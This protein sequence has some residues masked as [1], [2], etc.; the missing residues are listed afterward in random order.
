VVVGVVVIGIFIW[1][2]DMAWLGLALLCHANILIICKTT[3]CQCAHWTRTILKPVIMTPFCASN[4]TYKHDIW[5][6]QNL[7]YVT[8]LLHIPICTL[9]IQL[10]NC[11]RCMKWVGKLGHWLWEWFVLR[12]HC[13]IEKWLPRKVP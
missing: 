8:I 13:Q 4:L 10:F 3:K 6:L 12:E 2:S 5:N 7:Q 11:K 1:S 9:R